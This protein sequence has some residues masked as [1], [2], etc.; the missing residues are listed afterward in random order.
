MPKRLEGAKAA[1]WCFTISNLTDAMINRIL[2]LHLSDKFL[3]TMFTILKDNT[4]DRYMQGYLK[5]SHRHRVNLLRKL[6][7]SFAMFTCAFSSRDVNTTL[8]E[9]QLNPFQE[10]GVDQ[11]TQDFRSRVSHLKTEVKSGASLCQLTQDF[12]DI[13]AIYSL[14]RNTSAKAQNIPPLINKHKTFAQGF[15]T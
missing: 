11:Q 13:C 10:F 5:A 12:P 1:R 8:L 3:Y 2:G 14:S 4:G 15:R 7:G 6:I 9:I